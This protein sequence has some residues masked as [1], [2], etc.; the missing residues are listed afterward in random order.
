MLKKLL[1]FIVNTVDG[2]CFRAFQLCSVLLIALVL[3]TVQQVISRYFFSV[4][5]IAIQELQWH[6]FGAIITLSIPY[7]LL[8]NGHVRVD[9]LSQRFAHRSRRIIS[10]LGFF[11][12]IPLSTSLCY[13]GV[14]DLLAARSFPSAMPDD[15]YTQLICPP[16]SI[17]H[18][19]WSSLEQLLRETIL[20]GEGSPDP[21][22]LEARWIVRAVF[23]A[24]ILLLGL[25]SVALLIRMSCPQLSYRRDASWIS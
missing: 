9:I 23:P 25:Q 22:G 4:T 14:L 10:G 2:V 1:T 5:S 13:Y 7:T 6:L 24:S 11:L 17:C 20:V 16:S 12:L 18:S 19:F 3:L 8:Q 21:G 15:Y